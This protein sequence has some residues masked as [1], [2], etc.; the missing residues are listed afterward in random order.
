MDGSMWVLEMTFVRLTDY[1]HSLGLA[2]SRIAPW[3]LQ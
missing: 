3:V 1:V 2:S